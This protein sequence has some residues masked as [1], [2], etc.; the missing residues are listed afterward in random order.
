MR[1]CWHHKTWL[2][3]FIALFVIAYKTVNCSNI[4]LNGK[5]KKCDILS[6]RILLNNENEKT[7]ATGDNTD[8]KHTHNIERKKLD[9]KEYNK[10]T[11]RWK[12]E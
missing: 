6:S 3:I 7:I 4:Q 9:T 2:G 8:E 12:T 1:T 5:I 11:W 10:K